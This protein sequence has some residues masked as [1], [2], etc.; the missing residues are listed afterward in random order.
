MKLKIL[1][2]LFWI[3]LGCNES[4]NNVVHSELDKRTDS[5]KN[6]PKEVI[7]STG[8]ILEYTLADSISI[9]LENLNSMELK[10]AIDFKGIKHLGVARLQLLEDNGQ[11]FLPESTPIL[12]EVTGKEFEIDSTFSF[13]NELVNLTFAMEKKSKNS[14]S[15]IVSDSKIDGILDGFYVLK[16]KK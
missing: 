2:L 4:N 9:Q 6:A 14:L 12:D 3:H 7:K 15:F 5:T 10:Y 1:I 8:N 13:E 16:R 11:Y